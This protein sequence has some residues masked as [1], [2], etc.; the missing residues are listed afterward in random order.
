MNLIIGNFISLIAAVFTAKSSWARDRAHIYL[1]QVVQCLL[2]AVASI[3]FNSYA[4]IVTLLVCAL[5]NYLASM[6]KLDKKATVLCFFLVLI[7]GILL[8][9]RGYIG[10]IVIAANVIYT[11]GMY[12]TKSE[13]AIKANMILN[14]TLWIIYEILIIDVP[15]AVA[16]AAALVVAAASVVRFLRRRE[17]E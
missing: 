8:N 11:L 13:L 5:R 1:Y 9:N 6:G 15:S 4:G 17:T 12:L 10:G 7:P 3:F 2:L 16:D 14:L